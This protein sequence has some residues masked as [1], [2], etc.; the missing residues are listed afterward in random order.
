[1]LLLALLLYLLARRSAR[2]PVPAPTPVPPRQRALDSLDA[3]GRSGLV[4]GGEL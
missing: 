4:E 3:L 2:G 1:M